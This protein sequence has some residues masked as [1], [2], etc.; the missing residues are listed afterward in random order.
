[1]RSRLL[2]N[3]RNKN[4]CVVSNTKKFDLLFGF[5]DFIKSFLY[6]LF[7]FCIGFSL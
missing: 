2:E 7:L 6:C 4:R 5:N 1:M 3:V